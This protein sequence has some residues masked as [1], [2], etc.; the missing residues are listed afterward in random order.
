MNK[1]HSS[2][3]IPTQKTLSQSSQESTLT[4]SGEEQQKTMLV[5]EQRTTY[6]NRRFCNPDMASCWLNACLQLILTAISFDEYTARNSFTSELGRELLTL[7]SMSGKESLDPSRLKELI[8]S[9]EDTRIATR[10]SEISY[11]VI[12]QS[13]MEEQSAQVR[14]MRL[15]MDN[16][17]QC[18][19]DFF[20]CINQNLESWP[21]VFSTFSFITKNTSECSICHKRN[22]YETNQIYIELDVPPNN[23][24]LKDYVEDY[25]N[26]RSNFLSYCD[27]DCQKL[28][29]K[30]TWTSLIRSDEAKF[31]I[32]ILSRGIQTMDGFTF[33]KNKIDSTRNI[34]I[35]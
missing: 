6:F 7:F 24:I 19:R 18:V 17:Q 34:Q 32:V 10:L 9:S 26:N 4:F 30:I 12:N 22:A 35:R 27:G 8:I 2:F 33:V 16:G 29:D 5:D 13:L 25:F 11:Q 31:L 20:I 15:D 1:D 14:N 3:N 28:S 23:S 21:D